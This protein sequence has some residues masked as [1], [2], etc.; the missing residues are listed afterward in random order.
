MNLSE[1]EPI[2]TIIK[3]LDNQ[4]VIEVPLFEDDDIKKMHN[5]II[6]SIKDEAASIDSV[7]DYFHEVV[8]DNGDASSASKEALVNLI[9]LKSDLIDKMSKV[10]S[11]MI[12][13][14]AKAPVKITASQKNFYASTKELLQEIENE[15]NI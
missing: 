12:K 7:I 10:Y 6:S 4:D 2:K 14:K 15:K 9:K 5:E 1:K 11:E 13:T 3:E 8:V